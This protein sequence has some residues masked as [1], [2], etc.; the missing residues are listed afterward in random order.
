MS[1]GGAVSALDADA[2]VG[3]EPGV[4]FDEGKREQA[5]ATQNV[6]QGLQP[7]LSSG[8]ARLPA[9]YETDPN[10][11]PSVSFSFGT[12]DGS[13]HSLTSAAWLDGSLASRRLNC[14]QFKWKQR[15][16]FNSREA[17][18]TLFWVPAV[19]AGHPVWPSLDAH[20]VEEL[21]NAA[22]LLA[23]YAAHRLA[24]PCSRC[25]ASYLLVK[26]SSLLMAFDYLVCAAELLGEKMNTG[27]WWPEFVQLFRTDYRLSEIGGTRVGRMR[28]RLVNR[29]SAALAIY[30]Q[31][32][33]PA[34][35]EIIELK[36]VGLTQ[37][38][39]D[40]HMSHRLWQLWIQDDK[41]FTYSSSGSES[42]DS[43]ADDEREAK[44]P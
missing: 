44:L 39:K 7:D 17:E 6:V 12:A 25:T 33:R 32:K 43:Q 38:S 1:I 20:E 34:P 18:Q 22:E 24:M 11:R 37:V 2:W 30:K 8:R 13:E 31:G 9:S 42:S 28:K 10:A 15:N 27:K 3:E 40:S 26:L 35:K 29:L 14:S 16:S 21:M 4:V 36:R 5:T 41:D 23:N 19:E